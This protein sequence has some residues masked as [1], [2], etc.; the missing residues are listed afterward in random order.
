[1]VDDPD[2]EPVLDFGPEHDLDGTELVN[3]EI[4]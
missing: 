2:D 3:V 1:M 4:V